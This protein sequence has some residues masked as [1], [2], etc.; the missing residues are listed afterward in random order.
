LAGQFIHLISTEIDK[1]K[2][3]ALEAA[4]LL[5]AQDR[6]VKAAR[7]YAADRSLSL[8]PGCECSTCDLI[9][10]LSALQ[11]AGKEGK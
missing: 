5:E 10:A 6:V 4:A 3:A 1:L 2:L 8:K 9:E 11:Q 7:T